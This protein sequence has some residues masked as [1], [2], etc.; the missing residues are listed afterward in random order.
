MCLAGWGFL[1]TAC[2]S[3]CKTLFFFFFFFLLTSPITLTVQM[4]RNKEEREIYD[5]EGGGG[6]EMREAGMGLGGEEERKGGGQSLTDREGR[7]GSEVAGAVRGEEEEER[8]RGK[9]E[10]ERGGGEEWGWGG[11]VGLQL[12]LVIVN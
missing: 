7:L 11:G 12:Y 6:K 2:L 9:E 4:K 1:L 3:C 5:W 8:G 10:R